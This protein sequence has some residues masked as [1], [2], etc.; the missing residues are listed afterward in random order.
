MGEVEL[1]YNFRKVKIE[2]RWID[3]TS[4]EFDL[5]DLLVSNPGKVYPREQL[6]DI[7]WG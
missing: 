7:I 2:Q 3:L 6:L 5:M 4:K 1:D